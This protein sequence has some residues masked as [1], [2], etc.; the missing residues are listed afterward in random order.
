MP[1][2]SRFGGGKRAE[3]KQTV[4]DKLKAF[5]ERFFGIGGSSF[6]SEVK[7]TSPIGIQQN[8]VAPGAQEQKTV[9]YDFEPRPALKVAEAATEYGKKG[10]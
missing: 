4:I 2:V 10:V 3:K 6:K 5:F 9:S 1:P 8:I 7:A